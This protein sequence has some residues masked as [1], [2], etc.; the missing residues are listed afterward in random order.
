MC[1]L[2]IV[3]TRA[4]TVRLKRWQWLVAVGFYDGVW[5]DLRWQVLAEL[6]FLLTDADAEISKIDQPESH[7]HDPGLAITWLSISQA[8]ALTI[9]WKHFVM[10][11]PL[12]RGGALLSVDPSEMCPSISSPTT[13]FL[14]FAFLFV[15]LLTA[16][17]SFE[18]RLQVSVRGWG[19]AM[20]PLMRRGPGWQ[21]PLCPTLRCQQWLLGDFT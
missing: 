12:E 11:F 5:K 6:F 18:A 10:F 17:C 2:V 8:Y 13:G 9:P 7:C 15:L 3:R 4:Q 16:V 20:V 21:E 1:C 14:A 19:L